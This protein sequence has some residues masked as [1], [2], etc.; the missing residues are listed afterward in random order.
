MRQQISVVPEPRDTPLWKSLSILVQTVRF[1][2]ACTVQAG[3]SVSRYNLWYPLGRL[4]SVCPILHSFAIEQTC[5][6]E[7]QYEQGHWGIKLILPLP[8]TDQ[9][10]LDQLILPLEQ[11]QVQTSS[12]GDRRSMI[13]T[14]CTQTTAAF[15]NLFIHR[16]TR[17]MPAEYR[18]KQH[19]LV[20]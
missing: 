6:V 1:T 7:S 18:A 19:R 20:Q 16:G 2:T 17:W 12:D 4:F 5:T 9:Q 13:Y 11:Q 8:N 15:Y 10:E 14:G 3:T